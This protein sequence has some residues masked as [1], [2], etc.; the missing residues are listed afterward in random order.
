[1]KLLSLPQV[2]STA[3]AG[4][5][6]KAPLGGAPGPLP[7]VHSAVIPMGAEATASSPQREAY[8]SPCLLKHQFW[9]ALVA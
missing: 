8:I 2:V 4:E 5:G 6:I 1:M 9:E 7:P 3:A